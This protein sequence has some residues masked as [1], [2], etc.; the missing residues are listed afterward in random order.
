MDFKSLYVQIK[1]KPVISNEILNAIKT[2]KNSKEVYKLINYYFIH[3][4]VNNSND[5]DLLKILYRNQ[6]KLI[7]DSLNDFVVS[8]D[9]GHNLNSRTATSRRKEVG[10]PLIN[11]VNRY[12]GIKLKNLHKDYWNSNLYQVLF[13]VYYIINRK[14]FNTYRLLKGLTFMSYIINEGNRR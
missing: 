2:Q 14:D 7:Y 6:E 13:G 5:L 12:F 3:L 9:P 4:L 11:K 8:I 10:T 1:K